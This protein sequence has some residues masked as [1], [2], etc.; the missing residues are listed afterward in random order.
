MT[1]TSS[2]PGNP[3]ATISLKSEG[4]AFQLPAELREPAPAATTEEAK[5][6]PEPAQDPVETPET[7]KTE[8]QDKQEK[9]RSKTQ[10]RFDELTR[11]MREAERTAREAV[12]RAQ[13]L[14]K[15]LDEKAQKVDPNDFQATEDFRVQKAVATTQIEEATDR[16]QAQMA[17]V[18]RARAESFTA[19]A[20]A[21]IEA[22]P[23]VV[24]ILQAFKYV[25][26]S[27]Y[28]E[29]FIAESVAA[30][31]IAKHL[32]TNPAEA[33]RIKG[34]SQGDQGKELARLEAKLTTPPVRRISQAP[35]PVPTLGGSRSP[36][37]KD[38]ADM[39]VAEIAALLN[40]KGA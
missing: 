4:P 38:T 2:A 26:L 10:E 31:E 35:T 6:A 39:S 7:A 29:S 40:K 27:D 33:A 24:P 17:E 37:V 13:E 9:P 12:A 19:K 30:V 15:R 28:A 14:A 25:P 21:A 18:I 1:E 5:Q 16:A 22:D 8:E 34:M 32:V 20:E 23:S 36:A 3:G 11:K